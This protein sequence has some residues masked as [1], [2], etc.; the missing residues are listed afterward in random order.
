MKRLTAL[1]I[2]AGMV[3]AFSQV[4]VAQHAEHDKE[5]GMACC[6]KGMEG[7]HEM[8]AHDKKGHDKEMSKTHL[9]IMHE[10]DDVEHWLAAW[11]GEDSRHA[12]FEAHGADHVHVLT[13][14]ENPDLTGLVVAVTDMDKFMAMLESEEGQAAATE[15]GVRLDTMT[16]LEET[17]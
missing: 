6:E 8:G 4:T 14:G 13:S 15:D 5:G 16:I 12:L 1:T 10:V 3:L 7:G 11:H 2:L 17:R 9:V